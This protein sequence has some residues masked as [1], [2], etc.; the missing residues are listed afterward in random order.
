MLYTWLL[1]LQGSVLVRRLVLI[2][3]A[4]MAVAG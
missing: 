4:A 3:V 1:L 2:K